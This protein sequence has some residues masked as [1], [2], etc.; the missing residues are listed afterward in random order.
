MSEKKCLYC[1]AV[2]HQ[3]NAKKF[4]CHTCR[5]AYLRQQADL[6]RF[7]QIPD[8]EEKLKQWIKPIKIVVQRCYPYT[9][10]NDDLDD[11]KQICLISLWKLLSNHPDKLKVGY[12]MKT[13]E[14]AIKEYCREQGKHS[15][16]FIDEDAIF[17]PILKVSQN[18]EKL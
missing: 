5:G 10:T 16:N 2:I 8:F 13:F 1:G 17:L 11:F 14:I 9:K 18:N 7:K 12:L 3:R 4:C 15:Q 6:K